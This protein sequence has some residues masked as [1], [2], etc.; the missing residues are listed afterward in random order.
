MADMAEKE[1][2]DLQAEAAEA[3]QVEDLVVAAQEDMDQLIT[4]VHKGV[5]AQVAEAAE[6]HIQVTAEEEETA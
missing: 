2:M 4:L 1:C 5:T 6:T 3:W